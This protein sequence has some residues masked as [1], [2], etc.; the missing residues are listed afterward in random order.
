MRLLRSSP[1]Y[2][3][4][5][6]H[7]SC[8]WQ[9]R[10]R[11]LLRV[12]KVAMLFSSSP[13]LSVVITSIRP[14]GVPALE[15]FSKVLVSLIIHMTTTPCVY[16]KQKWSLATYLDASV[17]YSFS[18]SHGGRIMCERVTWTRVR[19]RSQHAQ[20]VE[21]RH[22]HAVPYTVYYIRYELNKQ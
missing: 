1:A 16:G 18:L 20:C 13:V 19:V 12:P 5:E 8:T 2:F 9:W 7:T 4:K 3:W 6:P 10:P 14:C 15:R 17:E 22:A 21:K 11:A